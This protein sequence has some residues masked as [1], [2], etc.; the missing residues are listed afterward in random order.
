MGKAMLAY[1][2]DRPIASAA[3]VANA[4]LD[5]VR[6]RGY[7]RDDEENEPGV[8]CVGA[9]IFE[10]SGRPIAA[11]SVSGPVGRILDREGEIADLL[12]STCAEIS[13]RLGFIP[14]SVTLPGRPAKAATAARLS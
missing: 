11:I 7:A 3:S 6:Q 1:M 5:A 8:A 14:A 13:R 2:P 9:P 10:A 4:Q 12:V